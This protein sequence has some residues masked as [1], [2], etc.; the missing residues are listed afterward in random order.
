MLPVE[1][2][3]RETPGSPDL[4]TEPSGLVRV[5]ELRKSMLSATVNCV[6]AESTGKVTV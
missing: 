4:T 6:T 1:S 5:T 3:V 2:G